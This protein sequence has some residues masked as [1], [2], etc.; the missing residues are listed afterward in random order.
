MTLE[1]FLLAWLAGMYAASYQGDELVRIPEFLRRINDWDW[2][3][4]HNLSDSFFSVLLYSLR[5]R[6]LFS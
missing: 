3:K 1:E 4:S 5:G 2:C 6:R